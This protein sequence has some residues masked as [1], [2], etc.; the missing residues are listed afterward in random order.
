MQ[1]RTNEMVVT[2]NGGTLTA[3]WAVERSADGSTWVKVADLSFSAE[4][5]TPIAT[6]VGM[7]DKASQDAALRDR[8]VQEL[9]VSAAA[10]Y[11]GRPIALP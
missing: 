2:A 7:V 3:S 10:Y 1:Y 8:V 4:A 5:S 11:N 9:A 6:L